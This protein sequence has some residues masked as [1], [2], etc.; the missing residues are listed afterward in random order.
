MVVCNWILPVCLG[1]VSV[2]ILMCILCTNPYVKQKFND[3]GALIQLET[4]RPLYYPVN[5]P[6]Y[7]AYPAY[8]SHLANDSYDLDV[9]TQNPIVSYTSP[10]SDLLVPYPVYNYYP[11]NP[12]NPKNPLAKKHKSR[13]HHEH[14]K[15]PNKTN[16]LDLAFIN[17]PSPDYNSHLAAYYGSYPYSLP[18]YLYPSTDIDK[19]HGI[20]DKI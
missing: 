11:Q 10:T 5:Y 20:Q 7:P 16:N 12:L 1:I 6:A 4:S 2:F 13:K 9:Q 15:H 3:L 14:R 19:V 8:P 18:S 17:R